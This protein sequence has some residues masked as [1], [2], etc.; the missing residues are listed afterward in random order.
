[1][2]PIIPPHPDLGTTPPT[3]HFSRSSSGSLNDTSSFFYEEDRC[4]LEL[5][6]HE[7]VIEK[8]SAAQPIGITLAGG[9]PACPLVYV[10]HLGKASLAARAGLELGDE[11]VSVNGVLISHRL[12][13]RE[14]KELIEQTPD[15]RLHVSVRRIVVDAEVVRRKSQSVEMKYQKFKH[16]LIEKHMDGSTAD[17]MGFTRAIIANDYAQ[18]HITWLKAKQEFLTEFKAKLAELIVQY[19]THS[20]TYGLLST[21]ICEARLSSFSN[22]KATSSALQQASEKHAHA[23]KG[24]GF[25]KNKLVEFEQ[26]VLANVLQMLATYEQDKYEFLSF[27][28]KMRELEEEEAEATANGMPVWRVESGNYDYRMLLKAKVLLKDKFKSSRARFIEQVGLVKGQFRKLFYEIVCLEYCSAMN[29]FHESLKRCDD[30]KP[31]KS[32]ANN[33]TSPFLKEISDSNSCV[34]TETDQFFQS[35]PD[36]P[37]LIQF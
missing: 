2:L 24:L 23:V 29:R 4:C 30:G 15:A 3:T 33:A 21:S 1:M 14:V 31:E 22:E 18:E 35:T 36:E 8:T 13:R 20:D 17:V 5:T 32:A 7:L 27:F 28:L 12:R 19:Q 25:C 34:D 26:T 9:L 16:K 6:E 37:S 10:S 11:L